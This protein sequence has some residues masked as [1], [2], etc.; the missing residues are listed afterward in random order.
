MKLYSFPSSSASYRT[1][2]A[3]HMKGVPFETVTVRLDQKE[4]LQPAYRRIN[5]QQRVPALV[6]DDGTILTQSLAII[7]YLDQMHPEPPVFSSDPVERAK[8]LAVAL[9]F[10]AEVQPLGNSGVI[11]YLDKALGLDEA[12]REEWYAHW[13]RAGFAAVEELIDPSP[14]CFGA[15]P[16][17]A[18]VCLVPQVFGAR[19]HKIDLSAFPKIVAV[20]AAATAL[21]AFAKAHPSAQPQPGAAME[22]QRQASTV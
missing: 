2:I 7:D 10:A 3:L 18:D 13:A 20:D 21:P 19:R 8:M 14:F 22:P 4:Q 6:L 12:R 17:I 16:S 1:R 9:A 5:P 11:A 15:Q